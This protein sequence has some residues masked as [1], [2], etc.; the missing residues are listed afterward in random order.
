[1]GQDMKVTAYF[2]SLATLLACSTALPSLGYTLERLETRLFSLTENTAS[3][4]SKSF[5]IRGMSNG[6]ACVCAKPRTKFRKDTLFVEVPKVLI[7][8]GL[9]TGPFFDVTVTAPAS[10]KRVVFGKN[11]EEIWPCD[12]A[13]I[14]LTVEEENA[15]LLATGD[16]LEKH[17]TADIRDYSVKVDKG[18]PEIVFVSFEEWSH[19]RPSLRY[20]Y[21]ID[22]QKKL[23]VNRAEFPIAPK[24]KNAGGSL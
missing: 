20:R 18:S 1:M 16:L 17:P 10:V 6:S 22:T 7:S 21:K 15:Q 19:G 11:K 8:H 9:K 23:I 2:I 5:R 13:K 14:A 3:D 12:K 24:T 4:G